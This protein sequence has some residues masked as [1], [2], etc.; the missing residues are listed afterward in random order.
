M[1][2]FEVCC[3]ICQCPDEDENEIVSPCKCKGSVKFI[4]HQCLLK[5]CQTRER[6][7]NCELCQYQFQTDE[8]YKNCFVKTLLFF[9]ELVSFLC[10]LCISF[11][12]SINLVLMLLRQPLSYLVTA[13]DIDKDFAFFVWFVLICFFYW[14]LND[15]LSSAL[16]FTLVV[17]V[18]NTMFKF[19]TSVM[20]ILI[21]FSLINFINFTQVSVSD[22]NIK[23][24][25]V[26]TCLGEDRLCVTLNYFKFILMAVTLSFIVLL[27]RDFIKLVFELRQSF[28]SFIRNEFYSRQ[29][30]VVKFVPHKD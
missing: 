6:P 12:I 25:N 26:F 21:A 7:W 22:V 3:R 15:F 30:R 4:H 11:V 23:K 16:K 18:K 27:C 17:E 19:F 24:Q 20:S 9:I 13:D 14:I 8:V 10:C 1:D 28:S 5:W 2:D 29:W